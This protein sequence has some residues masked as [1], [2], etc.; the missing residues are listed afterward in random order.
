[1]SYVKRDNIA[2]VLL[3]NLKPFSYLDR[4]YK[5]I[6]GHKKLLYF[7]SNLQIWLQSILFT[8][9]VHLYFRLQFQLK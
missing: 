3:K 6:S 2:M 4:Y 8:V 5:H 7:Y 1:M 9:S